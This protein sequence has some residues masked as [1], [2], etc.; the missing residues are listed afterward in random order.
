M[1]KLFLIWA[2][3]MGSAHAEAVGYI[4]NKAGGRIVFTNDVC[5]HEK[6]REEFPGLLQ[7]YGYASSGTTIRGCF[8]YDKKAGVL[9][10]SWEHD[11]SSSVFE[12]HNFIPYE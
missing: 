11:G 7:V 1:K 9:K 10:V 5:Y 6:K 4:P 2:V 12:A 8:W 3:L